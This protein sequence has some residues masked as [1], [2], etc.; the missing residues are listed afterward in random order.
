MSA[1]RVVYCQQPQGLG[2]KELAKKDQGAGK[3]APKRHCPAA[4][5]NQQ[6]TGPRSAEAG[7]ERGGAALPG[8]LS[9]ASPEVTARNLPDRHLP[10]SRVNGCLR[11]A[12]FRARRGR[13]RTARSPASL[14]DSNQ[15]NH[16]APRSHL[17]P[18][19]SNHPVGS[20]QTRDQGAG[21]RGPAPPRG[22]TPP[23]TPPRANESAHR[24]VG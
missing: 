10:S 1:P 20:A 17:G 19:R 8:D 6:K 3:A 21:L 9:W 23:P 24:A 5:S 15:S 18:T 12:S 16:R 14:A 13:R 7:L 2:G 11:R 22:Q 4:F